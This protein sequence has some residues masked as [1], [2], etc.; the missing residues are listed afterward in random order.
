MPLEV[1]QMVLDYVEGKNFVTVEDL[2][3]RF[4]FK[5][6]TAYNYLS[7]LKKKGIVSR[8]GYG[9]YRVGTY[10]PTPSSMVTRVKRIVDIVREKMPFIEFSIWSIGNLAEFS[11]Y[12]IG[13]DVAF[14][15]ADKRTSRKIRDV[16]LEKNIHSLV[17]PSR[18]ELGDIFSLLEE[19]LIIFQRREAYA[20][21]KKDRVR[22]PLLE[23]MMVDLYFYITRLGFPY[24]PDEYGRMFY[25]I[26]KART[27]NFDM[28]RKYASRR[29]VR[30]EMTSLLSRM[31]EKYPELSIP[32]LGE[33]ALE[34]ETILEEIVRGAS[35]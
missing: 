26:L 27:L 8:V 31:R 35:L 18:G 15:E 13:K 12:A 4:G 3:E 28:L 34:V 7:R 10:K 32:E 22:I 20:T 1:P 30:E 6:V 9:R 21:I 25:N 17:E 5:R 16:L 2:L 23:R 24:P 14:I 33:R 11:H 19:P 29:S